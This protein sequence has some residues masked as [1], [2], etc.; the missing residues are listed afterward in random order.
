[1]LRGIATNYLHIH[2][3]CTFSFCYTLPF[4]PSELN[5]IAGIGHNVQ[6][7]PQIIRG[8]TIREPI[9]FP[10]DLNV[11]QVSQGLL[12]SIDSQVNGL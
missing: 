7:K 12:D 10:L 8:Y 5:C 9:S 4:P 1:M 11:T 6:T 3:F 2:K